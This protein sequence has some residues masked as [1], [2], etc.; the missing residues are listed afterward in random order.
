M[1]PVPVSSL[2]GPAS[3]T[4][5]LQALA[6]Y[7]GGLNEATD[8]LQGPM[9]TAN[10]SIN[11]GLPRLEDIYAY[12]VKKPILEASHFAQVKAILFIGR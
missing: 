4:A 9:V 8:S 7:P 3:A 5:V 12:V 2:T 1:E 10:L 11:T 6:R